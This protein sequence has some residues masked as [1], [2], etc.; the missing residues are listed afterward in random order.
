MFLI[1]TSL[2]GSNKFTF[3]Y[4]FWCTVWALKTNFYTSLSSP[5]FFP[6]PLFLPLS[7][8]LLPYP[9]SFLPSFPLSC[10]YP[11][12][13]RL[14]LSH[15]LSL[16]RRSQTVRRCRARS[17][18]PV[19]GRWM[20]WAC[21]PWWKALGTCLPW[22]WGAPYC[23][24]AC[25]STCRPSRTLPSPAVSERDAKSTWPWRWDTSA[26]QTTVT[27]ASWLALTRHM[28]GMSYWSSC[29]FG[30]WQNCSLATSA[31]PAQYS[32]R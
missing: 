13:Q 14:V 9:V 32:H 3:H 6:L 7:A 20:D 8:F 17:P 4:S 16:R 22:T 26:G 29:L 10:S 18:P 25:R 2:D 27:R 12:L 28:R 15:S 11:W 24:Q 19:T 31:H 5:S 23:T 30:L 21:R 1:I